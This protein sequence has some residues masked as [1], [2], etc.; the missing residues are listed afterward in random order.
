LYVAV[1]L[2]RLAEP[3]DGALVGGGG[4]HHAKVG[5]RNE[6]GAARAAVCEIAV[7]V[8]PFEGAV[9]RQAEG[10]QAFFVMDEVFHRVGFFAVAADFFV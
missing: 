5:T 7:G 9:W 4:N 3:V 8:V 6:V 2:H 1:V 10:L